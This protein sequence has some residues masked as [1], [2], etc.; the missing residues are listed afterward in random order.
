MTPAVLVFSLWV[1]SVNC[2]QWE[3]T[4][5]A[6]WIT[7]TG[8]EVHLDDPNFGKVTIRPGA[9]VNRDAATDL[10]ETLELFCRFE[11]DAG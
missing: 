2:D 4:D 1:A 11:P 10:Y 8:A 3:R 7:Q 5:T 9:I 6:T